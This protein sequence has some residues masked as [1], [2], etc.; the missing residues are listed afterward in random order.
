MRL[1]RTTRGLA[2]GEG[3]ELLLL[4]LPHTDIAS[5]LAD[6]ITLAR[7]AQVTERAALGSIELLA[8]VSR[9]STLVVVGANYRDHVLEAGMSVPPSPQFFSISA[10]PDLVTGHGSPIVVPEEA[11]GQLDYEAE[12]AVIIG[13]GG[14]R[15][16]RPGR[17]EPRGWIH[18]RQRR[19]SPRYPIPGH[20]QRSRG[21][22]GPHPAQ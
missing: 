10:G 21:R 13:T 5:L 12:L 7:T 22:H 4:D 1:Y 17:L 19:V 15:H 14:K 3:D 2:R 18:R 6:D 20:G 8:P 9:P 16:P 11:A